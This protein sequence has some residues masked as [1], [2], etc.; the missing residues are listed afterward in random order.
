MNLS[1]FSEVKKSL[2]NGDKKDGDKL[3]SRAGCDSIRDNI[4][5]L[6]KGRFERYIR[7]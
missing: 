1:S 7:T 3:F 4:F 2:K 6:K 5:K